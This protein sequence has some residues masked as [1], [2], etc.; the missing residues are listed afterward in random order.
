MRPPHYVGASLAFGLGLVYCWIQTSLSLRHHPRDCV[1][2]AQLLNSVILSICIVTF[3]VSKTIFKVKEARGEGKKEGLLRPVYL[4]STISEWATA[5]A[6]VSFVLT[7]Y[8]SFSR[9]TLQGP[10]VLLHEDRTYVTAN[11]NTH[12]SN[13]STHGSSSPV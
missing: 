4:V 5:L 13:A 2:A 1:T 8:P 6:V 9:I 3:G 12:H 11:G 7:F 10:R